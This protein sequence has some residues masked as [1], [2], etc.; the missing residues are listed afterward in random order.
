MKPSVPMRGTGAEQLVV[1]VTARENES[2][3]RG[4]I[5]WHVREVNR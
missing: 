2:E 5:I 4:C 3:R 1:V